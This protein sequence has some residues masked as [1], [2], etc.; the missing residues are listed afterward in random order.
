MEAPASDWSLALQCLPTTQSTHEAPSS[1]VVACM[2]GRT[3][4]YHSSLALFPTVLVA[5]VVVAKVQLKRKH[6]IGAGRGE[7]SEEDKRA[8]QRRGEMRGEGG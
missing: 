5:E 2:P 4:K 6:R 7:E 8:E 3:R 1:N